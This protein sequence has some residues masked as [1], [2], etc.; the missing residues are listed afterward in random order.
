[1]QVPGSGMG[2]VVVVPVNG[3]ANRLQAMASSSSIAGQLGWDFRVCWEPELGCAAPADELFSQEF[4]TRHFISVDDFQSA[5]E[6]RP[7]GIPLWLTVRGSDAYLRGHSRG[8]QVFMEDLAGLF[9]S[10]RAPRRLVIVAGGK[11]SLRIAGGSTDEPLSAKDA[12]KARMSFYR[13]ISWSPAVTERVREGRAN[14]PNVYVGLHIRSTD[15]SSQRPS[16][17]KLKQRLRTAQVATGVNDVFLAADS[18][19]SLKRWQAILLEMG[20][21]PYFLESNLG[22]RSKGA[23]AVA[24]IS[25]FLLLGQSAALVYTPE[26]SFGYE[27]CVMSGHFPGFPASAA[28]PVVLTRGLFARGIRLVKPRHKG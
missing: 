16:L 18:E 21:H 25:D 9:Q 11:F 13:S 28:Q 4:M 12:W 1:M 23:A 19:E 8:E 10:S 20:F 14:L 7:E 6:H 26:S 17:R 2:Q 24:A 3:Y 27:A 22:D 5:F 15:R